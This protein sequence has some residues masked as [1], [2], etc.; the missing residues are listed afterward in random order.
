MVMWNYLW[1]LVYCPYLQYYHFLS[2]W[3]FVFKYFCCFNCKCCIC[4][5]FISFNV[6]VVYWYEVVLPYFW[7]W[8]F[9]LFC[10]FVVIKQILFPFDG[11]LQ[12]HPICKLCHHSPSL[13]L[14]YQRQVRGGEGL[15]RHN[16]QKGCCC[17]EPWFCLFV[18]LFL[19]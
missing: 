12:Q 16:L 1:R 11:S 14:T 9:F 15:W 13:P 5:T 2:N 4:F 7:F 17:T 19:L 3:H 6:V 8:C 10:W 18:F